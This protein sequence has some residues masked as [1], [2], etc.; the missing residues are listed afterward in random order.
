LWVE[1]PIS[2][3]PECRSN[4]ANN[5]I[6]EGGLIEQRP[7]SVEVRDEIQPVNAG[8]RAKDGVGSHPGPVFCIVL[9]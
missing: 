9:V 4:A 3:V 1:A 2:P 5:G 7:L 6:L 8:L